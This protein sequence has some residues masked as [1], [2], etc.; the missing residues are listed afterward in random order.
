MDLLE[1]FASGEV[2]AFEDLF[3]THQRDVYN[4]ILCLTRDPGAAEDLA[5]ETFWR[6]YRAHARFDP[7]RSFGAWARRIATNLAMAHLR[8]A[9]REVNVPDVLL[10]AQPDCPNAD[11]AEQREAHQA[12]RRAIGELPSKLKAVALLALI[13]GKPYAEIA[14]A[15]GV[16]L[17]AVKSREFRAVRLLRGK[18]KKVGIEP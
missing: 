1:R 7:R 8:T 3:R 9:G 16:S 10:D 2:S 11:S 17:A 5:L 14:S 18:L 12:I 13:E 4:W 15:L 6:L